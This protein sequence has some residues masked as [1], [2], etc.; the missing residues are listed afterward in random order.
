MMDTFKD[1]TPMTS[2]NIPVTRKFTYCVLLQINSE[3]VANISRV[4]SRNEGLV[5]LPWG[6]DPQGG[7]DAMGEEIRASI[8]NETALVRPTASHFD[9]KMS[10]AHL[11]DNTY[12][13]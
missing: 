9:K 3:N 2:S 5:V 13:L 12:F 1:N 6:E 8:R 10:R 4:D 7:W 11:S